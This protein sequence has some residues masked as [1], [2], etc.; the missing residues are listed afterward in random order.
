MKAITNRISSLSYS[1]LFIIEDNASSLVI[2]VNSKAY[3]MDMVSRLRISILTQRTCLSD[4]HF[5]LVLLTTKG[6]FFRRNLI[7]ACEGGIGEVL[8][9]L[10]FT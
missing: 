5:F 1:I 10:F 7:K 3:Y 9:S 2:C 4:F 6:W 8:E